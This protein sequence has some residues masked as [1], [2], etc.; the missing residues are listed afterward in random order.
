[1]ELWHFHSVL[2]LRCTMPLQLEVTSSHRPKWVANVQSWSIDLQTPSTD[3]QSLCDDLAAASLS[4]APQD[5]KEDLDVEEHPAFKKLLSLS[6][7]LWG[8]PDVD[9][10]SSPFGVIDASE[11]DDAMQETMHVMIELWE[12]HRERVQELNRLLDD[13]LEAENICT[14]LLQEH[15]EATEKPVSLMN[16]VSMRHRVAD[17]QEKVRPARSPSRG[18][19]QTQVW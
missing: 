17:M 2:S 6:E 13:V 14:R 11:E 15:N 16:S 19:G 1:V 18:S 10:G 3:V 12:R 4:Q 9:G 8:K 5:I 7:R